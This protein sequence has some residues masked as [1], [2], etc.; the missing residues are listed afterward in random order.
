MIRNTTCDTGN[1]LQHLS[2][3]EKRDENSSSAGLTPNTEGAKGNSNPVTSA[4]TPAS[5]ALEQNEVVSVA[6]LSV[7]RCTYDTCSYYLY[8]FIHE[9]ESC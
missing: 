8:A 1:G 5:P 2:M 3:A 6:S 4:N 7:G 9:S